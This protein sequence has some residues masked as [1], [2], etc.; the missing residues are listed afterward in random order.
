MGSG[1]KSKTV[2]GARGKLY[3][4]SQLAGIF[5]SVTYS[6]SYDVQPIY[7]L[8]RM[9]AAE[10]VYTG[11]APVDIQASGFRVM[12][13]GPYAFVNSL[14]S[15]PKLQ[16][17]LN[18]EDISI[19]LIDRQATDPSKAVI[20]TVDGVRPTGFSGTESARA[21]HEISMSFMGITLSDESSPGQSDPTGTIYGV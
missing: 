6:V 9:N 12:E 10:L 19:T 15:L 3:I 8:G 14:N 13:K 5:T 17:L 4:G 11:M 18:H 2:T 1:N 7:V 21:L 16:D 20:M